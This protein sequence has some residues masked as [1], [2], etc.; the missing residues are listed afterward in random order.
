MCQV[1]KRYLAGFALDYENVNIQIL[2]VH[3]TR[4]SN[5]AIDK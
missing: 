1:A 5:E 2:G 4:Y 3:K